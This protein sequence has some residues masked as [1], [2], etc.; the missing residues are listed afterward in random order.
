VTTTT[1]EHE[2]SMWWALSIRPVDNDAALTTRRARL[3]SLAHETA[4]AC[5]ELRSGEQTRLESMLATLGALTDAVAIGVHADDGSPAVRW[6]R[7]HEEPFAPRSPA[8][9][10]RRDGYVFHPS[11]DGPGAAAVEVR[12]PGGRRGGG[13]MTLRLASV[14]QWDDMNADLVGIVGGL[15]LAAHE[16]CEIE[17]QLSERTRSDQL[18]GLLNSTATKDDLDRWLGDGT[19]CGVDVV[20]GDLDGFK[21]L[22]DRFGHRRG[23][24]LLR[25]VADA[26]RSHFGRTDAVLGRVGGDEFVVAQ[27]S[28]H[29]DGTALLEACRAAMRTAISS[30]DLVDVS[31]GLASSIAGDTAIE[32]LH[33]ADMAMY[34]EKRGRKAGQQPLAVTAPAG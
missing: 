14:A 33:R 12:L 11:P 10:L 20:F 16:R 32:L 22:N 6:T 27:R 30:D 23:D 28:D 2:D 17:R 34:R 29:L 9:A 31:L 19:G 24:E 13:V 18:T 5:S 26:L 4:L 21:A 8:D 7:S 25:R 3:Q 1:F 15:V